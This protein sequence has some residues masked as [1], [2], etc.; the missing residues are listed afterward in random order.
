MPV[1]EDVSS[2]Q[3]FLGLVN[4]YNVFVPNMHNLRGQLNECGKKGNEWV[5]IAESFQKIK[6]VLISNLFLTHYNP[7]QKIIVASDAIMVLA[8]ASYGWRIYQTNCSCV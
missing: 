5:W 8:P 3:S 7:K 4:Y 2:L 6:E 1:S